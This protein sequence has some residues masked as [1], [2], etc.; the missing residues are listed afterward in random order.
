MNIYF[1]HFCQKL[2]RQKFQ[3]FNN[4]MCEN[5]PILKYLI[6]KVPAEN[7]TNSKNS[8]N[9]YKVDKPRLGNK[10]LPATKWVPKKWYHPNIT[11]FSC[12]K[13]N[14]ILISYT[15]FQSELFTILFKLSG[16]YLFFGYRLLFFHSMLVRFINIS[17]ISWH[18]SL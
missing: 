18:C 5:G 6:Y 14:S 13:L 12:L 10:I 8:M 2:R 17:A 15:T 3:L 11:L 16:E 1:T 7:C 9:Y 4:L